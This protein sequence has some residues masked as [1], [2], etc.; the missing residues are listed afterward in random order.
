[1]APEFEVVNPT[2]HPF[3]PALRRIRASFA[4]TAAGLVASLLAG[5]SMDS[6][7]AVILAP[8]V[9]QQCLA[10][11]QAALAVTAGTSWGQSFTVGLAGP[12]TQIDFQLGR[13]ASTSQPLQVELR[14]AN[15][16]LPDPDPSALLFSGSIAAAM[17]PS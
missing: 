4:I 13:N 7:R 9:D 6:A 8:T 1:V 12:L 11:I 15:G 14:L 16:D 2:R 3:S 17:S 10:P 5:G